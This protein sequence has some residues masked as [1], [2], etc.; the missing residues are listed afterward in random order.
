MEQIILDSE[1]RRSLV[2]DI[3]RDAIILEDIYQSMNQVKKA[4]KPR[5]YNSDEDEWR[6][7]E[8]PHGIFNAYPLMGYYAKSLEEEEKIIPIRDEL[9]SIFSDMVKEN[10]KRQVKKE[11]EN[12]AQHVLIEWEDFLKEIKFK[13]R[14]QE[15]TL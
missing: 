12:L 13:I 3:I 5:N 2:L 1:Q 10:E 15:L 4:V 9:N 11:A 7:L 14:I 6:P 8:W